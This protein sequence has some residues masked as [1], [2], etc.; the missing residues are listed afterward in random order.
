MLP[1]IEMWNQ[2]AVTVK[3]KKNPKSSLLILFIPIQGQIEV[4]SYPEMKKLFEQI[5]TWLLGSKG[6]YLVEDQ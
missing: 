2:E 1:K 6:I 4:G 3:E 5:Q